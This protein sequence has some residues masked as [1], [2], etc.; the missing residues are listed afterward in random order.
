MAGITDLA[1]RILL[2]E[3]G[4]DILTTELL[5]AKSFTYGS[6]RTRFMMQT[7]KN[8]QP[9]GIQIFGTDIFEMCEIAKYGEENGASFIDINCGCPVPKVV[10]SGAGSAM[11]INP[12]KIVP[13]LEAL[14]K[15]INI[16]L[17]LKIRTGWDSDHVTAH[18]I[19]DI[20]YE[21]GF[22]WVSIHG[23]TKAQGYS[24]ENNWKLIKEITQLA[25]LPIVG[26]GD[27]ID[28][29][30]AHHLLENN[31]CD[32]LMIGRK[33]LSDPL[34]FL[35]IKN[36]NDPTKDIFSF[37]QRYYELVI[38]YTHPKICSIKLKKI[39]IYL[40]TSWCNFS[41]FRKQLYQCPDNPDDIRDCALDFFAK[42]TKDPSYQYS[43][44][45]KGGHG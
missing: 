14:R 21:S 39:F 6:K 28:S 25:K 43:N 27:V 42:N 31:Y 4:A 36:Q 26:N 32:H 24:G 20:A 8:E 7:V 45:L 33:V 12:K 30:Q 13:L 37:I 22:N 10:K 34:F 40:A 2:K 9:C 19:V 23:R 44:F 35:N 29:Q 16:P 5:S 1:Y 18:E 38:E 15:S 3:Y 17:S 11:L 41:E